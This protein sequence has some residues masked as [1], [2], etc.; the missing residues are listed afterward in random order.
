[1]IVQCSKCGKK[2]KIDPAKVTEKGVKFSCQSCGN[3]MVIKKRAEDK[4]KEDFTPCSICGQPATQALDTPN[5][6]CDRCFEIEQEKTSRFQEFTRDEGT[7][8]PHLRRE[9]ELDSSQDVSFENLSGGDFAPPAYSTEVLPGETKTPSVEEDKKK[10]QKVSPPKVES[11]RDITTK[12]KTPQSFPEKKT[13][14]SDREEKK[15]T[16]IPIP[17]TSKNRMPAQPAISSSAKEKSKEKIEKDVLEIRKLTEIKE[18]EKELLQGGVQFVEIS[19]GEG[20]PQQQSSFPM[21][22]SL[23]LLITLLLYYIIK[24]VL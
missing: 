12:E 15:T 18:D 9:I 13:V 3:V 19:T 8:P 1:M 5:P 6:L 21:F 20:V 4:P 16:S 24:F 2:Y 11:Q 10:D 14:K 22:L 7:P 17:A 23:L